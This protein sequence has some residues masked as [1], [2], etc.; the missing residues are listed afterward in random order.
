MEA[1]TMN[2]ERRSDLNMVHF[3][4]GELEALLRGWQNPG[5]SRKVVHSMRE[6]GILKFN[7]VDKWH[8]SEYG[9]ELFR[10]IQTWS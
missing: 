4:R 8:L 5:I 9:D 10:E 1:F 2:F 6:R 3:F 7:Q